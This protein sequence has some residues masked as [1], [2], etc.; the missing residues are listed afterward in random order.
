MF[1]PAFELSVDVDCFLAQ[2]LM[3]FKFKFF[4]IGSTW[5]QRGEG[6]YSIINYIL[7]CLESQFLYTIQRLCIQM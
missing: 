2:Y 1:P 5:Q 4:V 6:M 3:E 7:L